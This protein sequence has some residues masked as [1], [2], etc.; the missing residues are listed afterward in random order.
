[1]QRLKSN[2]SLIDGKGLKWSVAEPLNHLWVSDGKTILIPAHQTVRVSL[3]YGYDLDD[4]D[5]VAAGITDWKS[6]E[7]R[8]EFALHLLRDTDAFILLDDAHHYRIELP[9]HELH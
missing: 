6:E 5:P 1:M 7:V 4:D 8:K 9:L 3:S 2:R